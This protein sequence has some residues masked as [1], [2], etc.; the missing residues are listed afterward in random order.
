MSFQKI[1]DKNI[2]IR[3][4]LPKDDFTVGELLVDAFVTMYA[5]KRPDFTVNESRRAELR[6][7]D[8]RRKNGM[9]LI[10]E[11]DNQILGTV[12][13]FKPNTEASRVWR[14]G[15]SELRFLAVKPNIQ[16]SGIGGPLMAAAE[17][18]CKLW[19]SQGISIRVRRGLDGLS[20]FY[21]R[22]GFYRDSEG[23]QELYDG[24]VELDGY[25][26]DFKS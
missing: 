7:I 24:Q 22:R 12:T 13:I 23:D 18:Q 20:E 5:K 9:V 3:E 17:E 19:G 25:S 6:D 2:I 10:A 4:A 16:G 8:S 21:K 26:L 15:Y 14:K 11:S 1:S